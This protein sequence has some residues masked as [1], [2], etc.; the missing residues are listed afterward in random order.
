MDKYITAEEAAEILNV[1]V[2]WFLENVATH[3]DRIMRYGNTTYN[4]Q[5]VLAWKSHND[6]LR[7]AALDE[8]SALGEE[9]GW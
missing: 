7:D 8:L 3:I 5:S 9:M 2:I 1:S 4:R 6:R